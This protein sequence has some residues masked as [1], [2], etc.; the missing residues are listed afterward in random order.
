MNTDKFE[1]SLD[2]A[3]EELVDDKARNN[4]MLLSEMVGESDRIADAVLRMI[5][6]PLSGLVDAQRTLQES[7]IA[8]L[9]TDTQ[10]TEIL[11]RQA[12]DDWIDSGRGMRT[13]THD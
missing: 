6:A 12:N 5:Q 13:G 10:A 4:Y 3:I 7:V 11:E 8:Y 1:K 2:L 9:R